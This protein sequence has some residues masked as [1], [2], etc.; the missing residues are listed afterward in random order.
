MSV[1]PLCLFFLSILCIAK[2]AGAQPN[3]KTEEPTLEIAFYNGG[4]P[5]AREFPEI[6]SDE[7][8]YRMGS[9]DTI[10]VDFPDEEVFIIIRNV[11][12]IYDMN[13]IMPPGLHGRTSLKLRNVN[14][15]DVFTV[16]LEPLDYTF[17][18]E[19]NLVYIEPRKDN[20]IRGIRDNTLYILSS[21]LLFSLG[22]NVFLLVRK[23]SAK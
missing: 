3:Q 10:S 20:I 15:K 22:L 14:W 23:P 6:D 13:V 5:E 11:A 16:I 17:R 21:A 7:M 12:D 8:D 9:D 2:F 18:E 4:N 19:G 1:K